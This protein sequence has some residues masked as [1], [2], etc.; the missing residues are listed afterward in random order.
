VRHLDP[1]TTLR[2]LAVGT[3]FLVLV[4]L[5]LTW[6]A[7][8]DGLGQRRAV[9]TMLRSVPAGSVIGEGDVAIR[10]WPV[11]LIPDGSSIGL[12]IGEIA[13]SHLFSGEV[14]IAERLFP[15]PD[16]LSPDER[17]V[18]VPQPIAP[19]PLQRGTRVEL[20]GMMSIGD[21]FV[22]PATRLTSGVVFEVSERSVAVVV[23]NASV[24]SVIEHLAVGTIDVV[25]RP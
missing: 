2:R 6:R 13:A 4:N 15:T 7:T 14:V 20:Y 1:R 18:T 17:L 11:D 8:I 10:E 3:A 25:V 19:P 21:G 5:G 24:P 22:S 23:G 9:A 12:P 16:G